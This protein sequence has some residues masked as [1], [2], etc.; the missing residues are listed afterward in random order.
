MSITFQ[1]CQTDIITKQVTPKT[2]GRFFN[3]QPQLY[4][5]LA[6]LL[7][8][9]EQRH[10]SS[11]S[12]AIPVDSQTHSSQEWVT[13]PN[14]SDHNYSNKT[15]WGEGEEEEEEDGGRGHTLRYRR[16]YIRL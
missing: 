13:Q 7:P 15:Q 3:S 2:S 4:F 5:T 12:Y 9:T 16:H 10:T 6:C 14:L 1:T 8:F 11:L